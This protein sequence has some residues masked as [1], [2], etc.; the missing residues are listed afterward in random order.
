MDKELAQFMASV[1]GAISRLGDRVAA[2]EAKV[3]GDQASKTTIEEI[4][5]EMKLRLLD[6]LTLKRHA[7][8]TA[9]LGGQ[10]YQQIA[11][12]MECDVTTVKLSLRHAMQFLGIKSRSMLLSSHSKIL[13]DIP[14]RVYRE[15]FGVGKTWWM[16]QMSP[17]LRSQLVAI[18]PPANQHTKANHEEA[19]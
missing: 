18:K 1:E 4:E 6:K 9:T 11:A 5:R 17:S 14:D 12:L 7:V 8:L 13:D 2:I 19:D 3:S 15:R 10:S 16:E